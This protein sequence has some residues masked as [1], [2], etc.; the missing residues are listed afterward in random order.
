[1][2]IRRKRIKQAGTLGFADLDYSE[3]QCNEI[4]IERNCDILDANPD[5]EKRITFYLRQALKSTT[6]VPKGFSD[7]KHYS[8]SK[9][10]KVYDD[11]VK[12]NRIQ[13]V[14]KTK[15]TIIILRG[16]N[17]RLKLAVGLSADH[18]Y[19]ICPIFHGNYISDQKGYRQVLVPGS[20]QRVKNETYRFSPML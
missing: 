3:Q 12:R 15:N 1:M 11:R 9:H 10:P 13:Y 18:T 14:K 8:E 19:A 5:Y 6:F 4:S 2:R 16:G 7:M 17:N 20:I